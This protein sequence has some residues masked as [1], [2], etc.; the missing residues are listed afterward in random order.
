MIF[1]VLFFPLEFYLSQDT[2]GWALPPCRICYL[3]RQFPS[4]SGI[5]LLTHLFEVPVLSRG[6][7]KQ[8]F[9]ASLICMLCL[10][11]LQLFSRSHVYHFCKSI[12]V[13]PLCISKTNLHRGVLL[14]TGCLVFSFP[15]TKGG[16]IPCCW[17]LVVLGSV[18]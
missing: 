13:Q 11:P 12:T 16:V 10:F 17:S 15:V 2:C 1:L 7:K 3:F 6:C 4:E 8:Y 14:F 18:V 5:S 9:I